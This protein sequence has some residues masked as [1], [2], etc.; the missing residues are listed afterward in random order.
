MC[1]CIN[2]IESKLLRELSIKNE[3]WKGKEI[4]SVNFENAALMV[5]GPCRNELYSTVEIGYD[6]INKRG[7][8]KH[9]KQTINLS[10]RYCPF[11]GEK[12]E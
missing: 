10:Y 9:K 5:T 8:K 2:E 11:C 12:Y 1:N 3:E 7:D 6:H 4:T